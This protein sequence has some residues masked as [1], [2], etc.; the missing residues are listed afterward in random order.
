MAEKQNKPE[1][2]NWDSDITLKS[3][4]DYF[5]RSQLIFGVN[6]SSH[7]ISHILHTRLISVTLYRFY[8]YSFTLDVKLN[9][10]T[11]ALH[12]RPLVPIRL[13]SQTSRPFSRFFVP[14][15]FFSFFFTAFVLPMCWQSVFEHMLQTI[16]SYITNNKN[17]Y[18]YI[19]SQVYSFRGNQSSTIPLHSIKP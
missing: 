7:F 18:I 10:S 6:F 13:L 2:Q 8:S 14:T 17:I 12:H 19:L 9:C 4:T 5:D 1:C 11:N 15:V 3:P 16:I